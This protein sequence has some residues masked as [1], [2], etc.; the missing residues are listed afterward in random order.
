M[1]RTRTQSVSLGS[2]TSP[3][4][5]HLVIPALALTRALCVHP[6]VGVELVGANPRVLCPGWLQTQPRRQYGQEQ[7]DAHGDQIPT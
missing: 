5:A 4:P 2:P 7:R 6:Q 1:H 3:P